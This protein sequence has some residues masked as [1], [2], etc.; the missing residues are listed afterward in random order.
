MEVLF[1][2]QSQLFAVFRHSDGS[3]TWS[4][5]DGRRVEA[6]FPTDDGAHC[7]LLL[8]LHPAAHPRFENLFCVDREGKGVWTAKLPNTHDYFVHAHMEPDG[9][10]ATSWSGYAITFDIA[11][12]KTIRREFVK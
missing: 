6:A 2:I 7:I 8:A 1:G 3:I 12:G 5:Y 11:T 9:L 10:H 4:D